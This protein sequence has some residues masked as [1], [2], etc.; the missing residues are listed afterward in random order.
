MQ[1]FIQALVRV[2]LFSDIGH[3]MPK[4]DREG[5]Y[6]SSQRKLFTC[7]YTVGLKNMTKYERVKSATTGPIYTYFELK[8]LCLFCLRK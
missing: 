6:T 5:I 3:S 8:M 7:M 1:C 4:K 2:R